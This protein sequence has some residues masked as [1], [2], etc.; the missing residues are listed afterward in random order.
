MV[1]E[2]GVERECSLEFSQGGVVLALVKQD[3][4]KLS[5]SLWQAGVEVR[6]CL[7]QFKGAIERNGTEMVAIE[8]FEISPEVIPGQ[9]RSG[10][11]V[12][13]IDRQRLFEQTACVIRR[14]FGAS[15]HM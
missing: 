10:A 7:R 3:I 2:I 12:I 4:S 11:R 9:H 6:R 13:R 8:R 1:D 15:A 5:A 14:R